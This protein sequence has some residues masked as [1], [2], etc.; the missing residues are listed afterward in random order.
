[1]QK[2][3]ITSKT[4]QRILLENMSVQNKLHEYKF[5]T[6][7]E[8]L[9]NLYFRYDKRA[10]YYLM[11][12][13]HEKVE[14]AI[15]YLDNLY[16]I[17]NKVYDS[18]K[19][20]KLVR[21]KNDLDSKGLLI[22][23]PLFEYFLK[24]REVIVDENIID[25]FYEHVISK[26]KKI[27]TVH[28][29]KQ[30]NKEFA[31]DV[32]C[33]SNMEIEIDSVA[34]KICDLISKGIDIENIKLVNVSKEY[35]I[36]IKRIF[37]FYHIPISLNEKNTLYGTTVG[38]SFLTL[39]DTLP[40]SD[41][42]E[43]LYNMY[44]SSDNAILIEK[45]TDILNE[46][47][48]YDYDYSFIKPLL[49]YDMK[50]TYLPN[51]KLDKSVACITIDE[52][53]DDDYVFFI[54]FNT[55]TVPVS[56]K[57]EAY[58]TDVLQEELGFS[59][60]YEWNKL[61]KLDTIRA[62]NNIKN[63]VIS[64][65]I[66]GSRGEAYPSSLLSEIKINEHI[67]DEKFNNKSYSY[68]QDKL[69]L[70]RML[71]NYMKYGTVTKELP[72]L[73]NYYKDL[74]YK[75]FKHTYTGISKDLIKNHF[76]KTN[77]LVLSYTN[78]DKF[79]KCRFR[80]YLDCILKLDTYEETFATII[81]NYF[82][83]ILELIRREDFDLEYET[84]QFFKDK[85]LNKKEQFLFIKIVNELKDVIR[86][87]LK[88]EALSHH[89]DFLFE[90][91][92]EIPLD[93]DIKVTMKGFID[94]IMMCEVNGSTALALIDY[95]TGSFGLDLNG[96]IHGFNLQLPIYAY[97][98]KNS[99][100][101][102]HATISGFYIAPI[103]V[104]EDLAKDDVSVYDNKCEKMKLNGYSNSDCEVIE[105]FD[106]T[107]RASEV[108][109]GMKTTSKGFSSYTKVLSNNEI[110]NLV[111]LVQNKIDEAITDILNGNFEINPK[112]LHD[113]CISCDFCPY[114]DICYKSYEDYVHLKE[115][116]YKEFLGGEV[117]EEVGLKNN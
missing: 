25:K 77:G 113:K 36:L 80:Y 86:I 43:E 14:N 62:I 20:N 74:P 117:W 61:V 3:Y 59:K 70:A 105:A 71:D 104:S 11:Q 53:T 57:D 21:I 63:L 90:E 32:F 39:L 109:R 47:N 100:K 51:S 10:I 56:K 106:I 87:V 66:I 94:K 33:Y 108:I 42:L 46:Y 34:K 76:S 92:I 26:L 111:K 68:L 60:S 6:K 50:H 15:T 78:L 112:L 89:N 37:E 17:E 103:L 52:V 79:M 99:E 29:I 18:E 84:E 110:D 75:T 8:L 95:K 23:N 2:L 58:I 98:V 45:L 91:K 64:Y 38:N 1:M 114:Q 7:Q 31:H 107:Y 24:D 4:K 55:D 28:I 101:F 19:L 44:S 72:I 54:G 115:H 67:K 116:N 96:V 12:T 22:T 83:H 85:I 48:W 82:H 97:L 35:E 88:Q 69:K 5:M 81:G 93:R 16:Y 40:T 73:Y 65:K 13:Y 30:P 41:I 49:I 102:K 9:E 27:T